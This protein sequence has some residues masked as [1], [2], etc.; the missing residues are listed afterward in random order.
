MP[1]C[2]N[3]H[4]ERG[5]ALLD[6][7]GPKTRGEHQEGRVIRALHYVGRISASVASGLLE[8]LAP[9]RASA[10]EEFLALN[11]VLLPW[12]QAFLL[13]EQ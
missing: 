4:N 1:L 3:P 10:A 13:E 9:R 12:D 2:E 11:D 5:R 6:E 7:R 8:T